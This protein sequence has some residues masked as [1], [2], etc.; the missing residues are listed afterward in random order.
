[1][2][3]D[4]TFYSK[5]VLSTAV[6]FDVRFSITARQDKR[7]RAATDAIHDD[8]WQ[9]IPYWL[10]KPE[11]SGAD[12]AATPFT[13]F[14]S[15]KRHARQVRLVVRR[16]R[17]TR[18]PQLV[19]TQAAVVR[20]DLRVWARPGL[21]RL[22][23]HRRLLP[24]RQV[25]ATSGTGFPPLAAVPGSR[26]DAQYSPLVRLPDGSVLNG[27]QIANASDVHD[28]VVG[29]D[30]ARGT[31]TLTLSD[32]FARGDAVVYLSTDA[33]EAAAAALEG[34]T[35]APRLD[36]APSSGDDSRRVGARL[37][38][39]VRQRPD[40]LAGDPAGHQ[41]HPAWRRRPAQRPGLQ[42]RPGQVLAAVGRPPGC[43]GARHRPWS[44]LSGSLTWRTWPAPARSPHRAA[45]RG[46]RA[47]SS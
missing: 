4:S 13:V 8:A 14:A 22:P 2:R 17:P 44:A 34:A 3:A 11:V 36:A 33:T 21:G 29:V 47:T 28:K 41:Q 27:P 23:G 19:A 35:W 42:A 46:A 37:A 15:D 31:V 38:G 26:G 1:V 45:A 24:V 18:A 32:G 39:R 43:V 7:V 20:C 30:R 12:I 9:P 40:R 6:K 25:R 5:T 10:S 16:V